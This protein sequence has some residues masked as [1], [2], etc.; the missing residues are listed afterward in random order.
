MKRQDETHLVCRCEEVTERDVVQA[1]ESGCR[2]MS[3]V[4]RMTRA[5]MGPCQGR[6]CGRIIERILSEKTGTPSSAVEPWT[7][8]F[9]VRPV[10]MSAIAASVVLSPEPSPQTSTSKDD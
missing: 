10:R 7:V 2:T 9:P 8:R 1:I 6:T 4:K 5:G 3:E